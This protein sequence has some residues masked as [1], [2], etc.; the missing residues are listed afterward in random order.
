MKKLTLAIID[1]G[2]DPAYLPRDQSC[3]FFIAERDMI[4]PDNS[5]SA[6]IA[7]FSTHA[8]A[9]YTV[10][11]KNTNVLHKLLSIK[12]LDPRTGM[13]MNK[14]LVA[15]LKWCVA[16]GNIDIIHMSLG[17]NQYLDFSPITKAVE[18]L[19]DSIIVAA[20]S[21]KH[22]LTF[23]ACLPGVLGVRR[24][25]AVELQNKFVFINAPYDGVELLVYS[26]DTS[27]SLAA[28]II[29][30]KVCDYLAS[31]VKGI[32]AIHKRLSKESVHDTSFVNYQLYKGL[33]PA[34]EKLNASVVAIPSD[35]SGGLYKLKD[36]ILLFIQEGYRAVGLTRSQETWIE[37]CI[38]RLSWENE[39]ISLPDLIELY[40]NFTWPDIIFLHM[41]LK[42]VL[43]LPSEMQVDIVIGE[44]TDLDIH[45]SAE[46]L[47][48]QIKELLS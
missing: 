46:K 43:A 32:E 38:F 33:I 3:E 4:M 18:E 41:E 13:G 29:T 37:N 5:P 47:F 20:C 6:D 16:R 15:A 12:I 10:I 28:P 31:G 27:N 42:E 1:D 9:C 35:I 26:K 21:N 22:I 8:T 40:Y 17:T 24:C 34:W 23:P 7:T 25:D 36:L 45:D 48:S 19:P 11:K 44:S 39:L 30:A 14:S 2:I